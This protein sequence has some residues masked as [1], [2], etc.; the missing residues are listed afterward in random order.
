[1]P[2]HQKPNTSKPAKGHRTWPYLLAGLRTLRPNQVWCADITCDG[3]M[4]PRAIS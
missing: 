3:E 2:I 1:M 4:V